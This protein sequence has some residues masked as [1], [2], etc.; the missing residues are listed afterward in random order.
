[1]AIGD[2]LSPRTQRELFPVDA[3]A[4][5][6]AAL[7][8]LLHHVDEVGYEF[9]APTPASQ[10]RVLARADRQVGHGLMDLLGWSPPCRADSIPSDIL[11]CLDQADVMTRRADGLVTAGIRVSR[12]FGSLFVHS[13]FPTTATANAD[14]ITSL[15]PTKRIRSGEQEWRKH[16]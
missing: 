1:M 5:R 8:E 4:Q 6:S 12:V 7:L 14:Q 13:A 2:I 11:A 10:A 15:D 3:K 9:I 16:A